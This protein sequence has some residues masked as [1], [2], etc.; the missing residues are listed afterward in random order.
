MSRGPGKLFPL[1]PLDG[2]AKEQTARGADSLLD[3]QI[4]PKHSHIRV[5]I[6]SWL[7]VIAS[8]FTN[9]IF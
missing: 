3:D 5:Y 4:R 8:L 1:P 6:L 7:V 2:P 9:I